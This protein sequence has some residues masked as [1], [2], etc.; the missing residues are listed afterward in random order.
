MTHAVTL[1]LGVH[2]HQPVGNFPEVIEDAHQRCYKPF[3]E[4]LHAYP[5]FR[6]AAHFSGWLLD[7]LRERH[8]ADMDLLAEM[9]KRGQVELFS[10]GDTEPVLAAIPHRDRVGQLK[11]LNDKLAAWTDVQPTG[12]WLTERVWESAVVPA[13]AET[14]IRYVTVDDYHFF[15][16]GKSADELDGY[17]STEEDGT[18]LDLFPISE[19]LRY[20]LPFS[21]AH[22]VIAY[23]ESLADQNQAAAIYF[24]DIEKF[25][26]WPE[27]YDWVYN[28]GWLKALIEGVLASSKIRTGT[29]ADFHANNTTRGIVYLPTTSYSE[30]NEWTLPMPAASI[31]SAFLA[32]EKAAGRG[33]LHRPFM[34]GGIWRNFLS[35]YP[36]ANWMHKRMQGLSARLGEIANPPQALVDDLY[37][38]QAND[39]Y[40]HGLFGGLYLPHLRRAVWNNIVALEAELDAL[41]VRPDIA[42]VDLDFDGKTETIAHTTAL[43]VV[44]R[45]DG[46]AGAHELSSYP[47]MHNFGDTLRRYH[48]HYHD[49]IAHGPSEHH[50]EGIASA[51]DIVR[52][53]HPISVEDIV[54]DALPRALWLDKLDGATLVDYVQAEGALSFAR[55]HITKTY[56][57]DGSTVTVTW[58]LKG[59]AGHRFE[60]AL[61]LAMPSCDGFLGHYTLADGH[62]PGGFGQDLHL[63]AATSLSLD[64]GVL[65]GRLTLQSSL[66]GEIHGQPHQTV[67]Q[68]EAGFE[69]IMQAVELRLG[70]TIPDDCHTL[71]LQLNIEPSRP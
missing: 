55:P 38:A 30:M 34:R 6:F 23:L 44:I 53:K 60:T 47:L 10:S 62:I 52:F 7:W 32:A 27:T 64:D 48:E 69:K 29:Y 45:N 71:Q 16:T 20:R 61:N 50:G 70:W 33:D 43:Q 46:L 58:Q 21:P 42:S 28:R 31:Y 65:A 49:R 25:G 39:A 54:P 17:F 59:L 68:S 19:A 15:C 56:G 37:R 14:G 67:S 3:L 4:T 12:A 26:I 11:T 9:V 13:L 63:P 41:H 1:L 18:R 66:A 5:D 22:E 51:H 24:D 40:W 57:L 8:P 2:A 36:E 35:R